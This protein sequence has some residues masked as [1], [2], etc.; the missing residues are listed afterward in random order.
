MSTL[1]RQRDMFRQLFEQL[2]NRNGDSTTGA[3]VPASTIANGA[4]AQAEVS[5][6]PDRLHT[7]IPTSIDV[8]VVQ[9]EYL[10]GSSELGVPLDSSWSLRVFVVDIVSKS[11][12][13]TKKQALCMLGGQ[14]QDN[15]KQLQQDLEAELKRV[16][17]EALEH[18]AVVSAECQAA[19][20]AAAAARTEAA[21]S[22]V[23]ALHLAICHWFR[24]VPGELG[25][26][27]RPI[28]M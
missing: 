15:Y 1:V 24:Q 11:H 16:R 14:T 17:K 23:T 18:A 8:Y 21:C 25:T 6:A 26:R 3:L 4:A 5:T 10:Q 22:R 28:Y 9:L 13:T 12:V 20:K 19:Q 27:C 7:T 2:S